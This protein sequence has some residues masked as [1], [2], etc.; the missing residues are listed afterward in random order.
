M[1]EDIILQ[2][3]SLSLQIV[4]ALAVIFV[5]WIINRLV[6]SLLSEKISPENKN[7]YAE[8]LRKPIQ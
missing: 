6:F 2:A 8:L 5:A 1:L 3:K 7:H 4:E